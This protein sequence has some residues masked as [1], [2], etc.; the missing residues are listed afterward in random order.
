MTASPYRQ[1]VELPGRPLSA[2]DVLRAAGCVPWEWVIGEIESKKE[3]R[4]ICRKCGVMRDGFLHGPEG[5]K[6]ICTGSWWLACRLHVPHFHV[7][8][9]TC[10]ARWLMAPRDVKL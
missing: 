5:R 10:S 9:R 2:E 3:E 7:R 4:P 1:V 8:C 6:R